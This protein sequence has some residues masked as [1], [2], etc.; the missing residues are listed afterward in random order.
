MKVEI[1]ILAIVMYEEFGKNIL[2]ESGK[3]L[4]NVVMVSFI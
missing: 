2:F 1:N 3:D 4:I